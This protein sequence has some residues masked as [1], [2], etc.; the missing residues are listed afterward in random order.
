MAIRPWAH[1]NT[2]E[3][4][5]GTALQKAVLSLTAQ[6]IVPG[7]PYLSRR[8]GGRRNYW[9]GCENLSEFLWAVE[10]ILENEAREVCDAARSM[11]AAAL[12][13]GYPY[14]HSRG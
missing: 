6:V 12:A 4:V 1:T 11:R 8:K 3:Q 10:K 2:S 13:L 14:R 9:L 7:V 5:S